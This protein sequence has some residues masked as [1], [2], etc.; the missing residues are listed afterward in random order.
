MT[1]TNIVTGTT[2]SGEYCDALRVV[3]LDHTTHLDSDVDS[4]S[5]HVFGYLQEGNTL[6][7]TFRLGCNGQTTGSIACDASAY[8]MQTSLEGLSTIGGVQVTR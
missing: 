4:N 5:M 8:V 3:I 7:G 2:I 6:G 1:S